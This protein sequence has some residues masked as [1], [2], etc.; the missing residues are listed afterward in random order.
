MESNAT[1]LARIGEDKRAFTLKQNEMVVLGWA[2][3]FRFDANFAGHAEMN[4]KEVVAGDFEEHPFPACM[5][6]EKFCA[7]QAPLKFYYVCLA[8]DAV[9]RVQAKIDNFRTN[10]GIPLFAKPFDFGQ[11]WHRARYASD[12][13]GCKQT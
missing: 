7:D 12:A 8:K 3:I 13:R 4:E 6:A 9:S 2:I 1:E 11:L 10:P 5:R